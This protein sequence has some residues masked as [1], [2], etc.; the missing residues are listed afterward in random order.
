MVGKHLLCF[1]LLIVSLLLDAPQRRAFGNAG[2]IAV[3]G[4]YALVSVKARALIQ[5]D[6]FTQARI[7][8]EARAAL[9]AQPP[10]AGWTDAHFLRGNSAALPLQAA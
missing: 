4:V 10:G 1:C 3:E 9:C 8:G 7:T 5:V 6:L 2:P